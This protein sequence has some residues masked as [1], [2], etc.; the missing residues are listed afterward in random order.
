MYIYYAMQI[1]Q[2]ER[3]VLDLANTRDAP[4]FLKLMNN[5]NWI[6][7]IGDRNINSEKHAATYIQKNLIASYEEHGF[8]LYKMSL[9]EN[10]KPIGLCGFLKR[11]YLEHADIGFAILPKYEG[12]GYVLEAAK[13]SMEF[14]QNKLKLDTILGITSFDNKRS[15]NLLLRIGL[16]E[17]GK[18]T[19]PDKTEELLLFSN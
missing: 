12:Q 2:T 5:P 6:K 9:K 16:V 18:V 13:A 8:G 15:I 14:G 10:G 3:I 11:E 1:L 7:Y 17:I 19:P 4:F